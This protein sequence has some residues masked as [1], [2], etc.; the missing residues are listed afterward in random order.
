[1]AK[2]SV[3]TIN[4]RT[5]IPKNCEYCGSSDVEYVACGPHIKGTCLDCGRSFFNEQITKQRW[6]KLIKE[7]AGYRCERCGKL[8]VGREAHAH[9][10]RPQWF[11]PEYSLDLDNGICLCTACHKQIHGKG[12]TIKEEQ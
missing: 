7:R 4:G 5:F 10:L 6:D 9:H 1:M 12:G 3:R 11:M 2:P 8:L